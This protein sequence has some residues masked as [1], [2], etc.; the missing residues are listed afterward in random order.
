VVGPT[1]RKPRRF[2]SA[3]SAAD[4]GVEA[5]SSASDAG[6][7]R[8][9]GACAHTSRSREVSVIAT[10]A[11]ALAMAAATLARL[12]TMPGSASSRATSASPKPAT[13][14]GSNP[15]KARRNASR[16]RRMVSQESPA[17]KPSRQSFSNRRTSSWTGRPHSSSW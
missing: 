9:G 17:W 10:M 14:A 11:R 3:A 8:A 13:V 1:K 5:G 16:L 12:R 15:A 4:S 6:A 7:G 2:S